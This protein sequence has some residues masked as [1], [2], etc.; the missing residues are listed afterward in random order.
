MTKLTRLSELPANFEDFVE[1]VAA[2][3][4]ELYGPAA[5]DEYR[6]QAGHRFGAALQ[7]PQVTGLGLEMGGM[8]AGIALL[9]DHMQ[10]LMLNFVHILSTHSGPDA[11]EALLGGVMDHALRRKPHAI[12]AE[13]VPFFPFDGR[14][15][16]QK[17]GFTRIERLLMIKPLDVPADRSPRSQA[18]RPEEID[19][20]TEI[21]VAA[22]ADHPDRPLHRELQTDAGARH[23]V[24]AVLNGAYGGTAPEFNRLLRVDGAP[25][26]VLLGCRVAPGVGFVVQVAAR[27]GFQGRGLGS[28]LLAD[29]F[30][31]FGRAGLDRVALGVT[32]ASP[33][34][35]LYHRLGFLP[36]REINAYLWPPVRS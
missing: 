8:L 20:A 24:Q 31:A 35:R 26:A 29:A 4:A 14:A 7:H 6:D 13:C 15:V 18:L 5:A 34:R 33:A 11:E 32:A 23:Y 27:P 16:F 1:E 2:G 19:A 12:L 30:N 21:L 25:V 22:Y 36:M 9:I 28:D 17:R 10:R 3:M